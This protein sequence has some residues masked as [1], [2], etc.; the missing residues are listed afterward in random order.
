MLCFGAECLLITL[1]KLNRGAHVPIT[2]EQS[3]NEVELVSNEHCCMQNNART[4]LRAKI[5]IHQNLSYQF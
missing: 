3:C 1:M 4:V 2:F 5:L